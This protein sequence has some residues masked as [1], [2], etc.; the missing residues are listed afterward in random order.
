MG[1]GIFSF[2]STQITL[3]TICWLVFIAFWLI[4]ALSAKR[5]V[6][7][8]SWGM[9]IRILIAIVIVVLRQMG[10]AIPPWVVTIFWIVLVAVVGIFA[11]RLL[12]SLV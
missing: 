8:G 2:E 10:V 9:G 6:R 11:I 5:Y 1:T 12:M 4:S 7:R 3:V